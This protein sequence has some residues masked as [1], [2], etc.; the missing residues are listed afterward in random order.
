MVH[1]RPA[2]Q[3]GIFHGFIEK[4]HFP[5]AGLLCATDREA[6]AVGIGEQRADALVRYYGKSTLTNGTNGTSGTNS[7]GYSVS[8][9]G[10]K[11]NDLLPTGISIRFGSDEDE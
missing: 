3:S 10:S 2:W 8:V 4:G 6:V 5:L 1:L 9:S 11:P 7:I